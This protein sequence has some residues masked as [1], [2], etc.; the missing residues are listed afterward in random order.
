MGDLHALVE[1]NLVP[2]TAVAAGVALL[3]LVLAVVQ[4]R[5]LRAIQ[6][7]LDAITRGSH[8]S[9]LEGVLGARLDQVDEVAREVDELAART[10]MLESSQRRA[11]QRLGLVR[12]NPFDD[13]GGNQSFALAVLDGDEHGF[14]VSSLHAR[15]GTRVYAKTLTGGRAESALSAEEEEALRQA[16]GPAMGRGSTPP[17]ELRGRSASTVRR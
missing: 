7:R 5:R 8:G 13:T 12:Y 2:I 9:G 15:S 14:V 17:G 16:R 6:Q 4:A 3:L 10:A 11:F 1:S